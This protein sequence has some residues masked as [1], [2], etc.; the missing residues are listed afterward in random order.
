MCYGMSRGAVRWIA[1]EMV[2][3]II[4]KIM[5]FNYVG[6]LDMTILTINFY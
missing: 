5:R 3:K 1:Y 6:F 4:L 2:R